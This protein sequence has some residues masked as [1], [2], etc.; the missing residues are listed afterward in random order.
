M[1]QPICK[2]GFIFDKIISF[3]C[4]WQDNLMMGRDVTEL[5]GRIMVYVFV[6]FLSYS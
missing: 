5:V 6:Y 4:D 2:D 3:T 1:L